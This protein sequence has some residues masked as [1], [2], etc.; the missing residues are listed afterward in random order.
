MTVLRLLI[1]NLRRH[2]LRAFLG[3]VASFF[4]SL[5]LL[6][7]LGTLGAVNDFLHGSVVTNTIYVKARHGT[8]FRTW[9][10]THYSEE[11]RQLPGVVAVTSTE[12]A[13]VS[14]SANASVFYT[15]GI[16]PKMLK[17]IAPR[18]LESIPP[19]V[20][21]K[22]ENDPTAMLVSRGVLLKHG[23]RIG[24]PCELPISDIVDRGAYTES[25]EQT[26]TS[27]T[28]SGHIVGEIVR[29]PFSDRTMMVHLE[30]LQRA[31]DSKRAAGILLRYAD[32]TDPGELA[33]RIEALFKN[34]RPVEALVLGTWFSAMETFLSQAAAFLLAIVGLV[35]L[36]AGVIIL[37]G[38]AMSAFE[39]LPTIG[40][41]LANGANRLEVLILLAGEG[42]MVCTSGAAAAIMLI[43]L[44]ANHTALID[45]GVIDETFMPVFS[46]QPG[47]ILRVMAV[48]VGL[49][50]AGAVL[51]SFVLTRAPIATLLQRRT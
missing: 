42:L 30:T 27:S 48:A 49:S 35:G 43:W 18:D 31:L 12:D 37:H 15:W 10:P 45:L 21:E 5:L 47:T 29:G 14:L 40:T 28:L 3:F 9:V 16:D 4:A 20:W 50:L 17:V 11:M 22:F 51:P 25:M 33:G 34:R 38:V 23:F 24:Q 36:L 6:L 44:M 46:L 2:K 1:R 8:M 26:V 39:L 32:D 13:A 7:Y 19:D 41:L